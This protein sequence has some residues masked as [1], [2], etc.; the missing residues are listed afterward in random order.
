MPIELIPSVT[1]IKYTN[2]DG[3]YFR[4]SQ[5]LHNKLYLNCQVRSCRVRGICAGFSIRDEFFTFASLYL[6][7]LSAGNIPANY[8]KHQK[9]V[10]KGVHNHP[11]D[12]YEAEFCDLERRILDRSATEVLPLRRIFL[13]ETTG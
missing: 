1:G 5:K 3:Y 10:C 2:G 12:F 8:D 7:I 13:E 4:L 9:I 11:A 6:C